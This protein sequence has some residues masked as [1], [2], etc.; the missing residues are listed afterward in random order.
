MRRRFR[1]TKERSVTT[2]EGIAA[3]VFVINY[4]LQNAAIASEKNRK[5]AGT[6]VRAVLK[7]LS[8]EAGF[9]INPQVCV[10]DIDICECMYILYVCMYVKCVCR[11]LKK[12]FLML[13]LPSHIHIY[14]QPSS[15]LR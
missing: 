10:Y 11:A 6:K 5:I 9:M 7:I 13:F 14:I 15:P 12:D 4:A 3:F 1:Q 2:H 8:T